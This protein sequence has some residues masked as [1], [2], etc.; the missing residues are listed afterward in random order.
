MCFSFGLRRGL[1][2]R[3][4]AALVLLAALCCFGCPFRR[5]TGLPCPGCGLTRAWL[6]ALRGDWAA[7]FRAHAFFAAVPPCVWFLVHSHLLP[8]AHRRL[9]NRLCLVFALLLAV[10]YGLRLLLLRF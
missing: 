5:L 1:L 3:H 9:G 8:D 2:L 10:Y 6:H 7:A 4:A